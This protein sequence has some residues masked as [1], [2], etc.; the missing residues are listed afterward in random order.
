MD[1]RDK[2]YPKDHPLWR[3]WDRKNRVILRDGT[4]LERNPKP[5]G[6]VVNTDRS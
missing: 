2:V 4:S 3:N 6:N 5:E 1:T